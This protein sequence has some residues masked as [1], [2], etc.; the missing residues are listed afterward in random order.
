MTSGGGKVSKYSLLQRSDRVFRTSDFSASLM[1]VIIH[2]SILIILSMLYLPSVSPRNEIVLRLRDSQRQTEVE[3]ETLQMQ[4]SIDISTSTLHTAVLAEPLADFFASKNELVSL[5]SPSQFGAM[6]SAHGEASPSKASTS[7]MSPSAP[8]KPK[9]E[10]ETYFFGIPAKGRRFVYIIDMSTSMR[11]RNDYG[12]SRFQTAATELL[13]AVEALDEQQEFLVVAFSYRSFFFAANP[14]NPIML[15]ATKENKTRLKSWIY[16][17]QLA[18]GTDP[19]LGVVAG[20]RLKPDAIFL[21]SDGEFNGRKKNR[22]GI[23]GNIT[24]EHLIVL[25]RR[26]NTQIHTIALDKNENRARLAAIAKA[27]GGKHRFVDN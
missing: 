26:A 23:P 18:S 27:T 12:V 5:E 3:F 6:G 9:R 7:G 4:Q 15:P 17:L 19:R 13:R 11:A 24:T 1:S 10:Y 14:A 16:Q 21:L 2:V 8:T 22:Q 25:N 20:L